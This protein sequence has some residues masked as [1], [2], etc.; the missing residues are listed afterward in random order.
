[1]QPFVIGFAG[2]AIQGFEKGVPSELAGIAERMKPR[3]VHGL[4]P[5]V[6]VRL[7]KLLPGEANFA[8]VKVE[9][10]PQEAKGGK[11]TIIPFSWDIAANDD[12]V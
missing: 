12:E 7:V 4:F 8:K 5:D 10:L 6:E 11:G 9:Y 2:A 1:M 3:E